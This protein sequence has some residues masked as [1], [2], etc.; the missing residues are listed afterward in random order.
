MNEHAGG[1]VPSATPASSTP[2]CTFRFE[3]QATW[4]DLLRLDVVF[5]KEGS[6]DPSR[7][8]APRSR[9]AQLTAVR[10]PP[11]GS[12]CTNQ[13]ISAAL[14]G[15]DAAARSVE[16]GPDRT[17]RC[18][19]LRRLIDWPVGTP[20]TAS[21]QARA[22]PG[23]QPGTPASQVP[24]T[25]PVHSLRTWAAAYNLHVHGAASTNSASPLF[26]GDMDNNALDAYLRDPR[27][28]RKFDFSPNETQACPG[29]FRITYADY[30]YRNQ[31]QPELEHVILFFSPLLGSRMMYVSLDV[32]AK[33]H[34]IRII[35]PDRPGFGETT[36]VDVH[37]RISIWRNRTL[38]SER[39]GFA[40]TGLD[41]AQ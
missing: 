16:K 34:R 1:M 15:A 7:E 37:H 6:H 19:S 38:A 31:A 12:H 17:H 33:R 14:H 13:P 2:Q 5:A 23:A 22:Q 35:N 8:A 25:P 9:S 4:L 39:R 3:E 41:A 24:T 26:T 30:G 32:L 21:E 18:A 40:L 29:P 28:I 20:G 11:L 27:F 10:H 36:D